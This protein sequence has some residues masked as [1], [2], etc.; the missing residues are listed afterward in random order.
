MTRN[1]YRTGN[2]KPDHST[3]GSVIYNYDF[4][5][6]VSMSDMAERIISDWKFDEERRKDVL[7][8]N[9]NKDYKKGVMWYI[10]IF[11]A[12]MKIALNF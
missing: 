1:Y 7:N 9:R 3:C 8:R 10:W 6:Y 2:Y 5:G 4:D 11:I 12:T